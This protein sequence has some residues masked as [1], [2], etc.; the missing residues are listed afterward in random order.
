MQH[1]IV[2]A[3]NRPPSKPGALSQSPTSRRAGTGA[4]RLLRLSRLLGPRYA[5]ATPGRVAAGCCLR[6][7]RSSALGGGR[8]SASCSR[9]WLGPTGARPALACIIG[10]RRAWTVEMISSEE[11]P[12]QVG[13]GRGQVRV[14]QLALD[15][16]KRDALVQQLGLGKVVLGRR[17][18]VRGHEHLFP[19]LGQGCRAGLAAASLLRLRGVNAER[20]HA[21]AIELR[22]ELDET[23]SPALL[24]RLIQGL[25]AMGQQP[26]Q[27]GPEQQ[28]SE[29]R[30]TLVDRLGKAPSNQFSPAWRETLK[31]LGI[32]D[33]LG[34]E[35][36]AR[37][38]DIFL[39]NELTPTAA[40]G[41]LDPIAQRENA[42]D[43]AV[44]QV[45]QSFVFFGIGSDEL[46]PGEFEIGFLIPRQAVDDALGGLGFE[47][48]KLKR[49]LGPFLEVTTDTR[50]DP[51]IRSVSSSTIQIILESHPA[52]ALMFAGAVERVIT[53]YEKLMSIRLAYRELKKGDASD[54]TLQ[55]VES[56]AD[57]KMGTEIKEIVEELLV[58]ANV[59]EDRLNELR[60]DF[61]Q[62]LNGIANRIDRG[63]TMEV[64]A[65]ELPEPA[66]EEEGEESDD[67]RRAREAADGV[68]LL[69]ERLRFTNSSGTPILALP[70]GDEPAETAE[71]EAA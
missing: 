27:P 52:M 18:A 37:I 55:V 59:Q 13:A 36:R 34:D 48:L 25:Q 10:A 70:E 17:G 32:T 69:Q 61:E 38:E 63:Y 11:I 53:A 41:E 35:L 46:D 68:I 3:R 62:A 6:A 45:L 22:R 1:V 57:T 54:E 21:I 30:V 5:F 31:E 60:M 42:L 39:R 28:V 29:V 12:W 9:T 58:K 19:Y 51:K 20:L 49:I 66:N 26:G 16:R 65:G 44:N 33:V 8:G 14:S 64:R 2:L 4:P 50:E 24:Q 23:E 71:P 56:E 15:Q 67:E 7:K 47:L 43:N 40:V